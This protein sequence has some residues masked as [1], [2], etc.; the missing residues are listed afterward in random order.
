MLDSRTISNFGG[1]QYMVWE[2][3]GSIHLSVTSTGDFAVIAGI[4]FD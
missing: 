1:G 2:L 4:F 3:S